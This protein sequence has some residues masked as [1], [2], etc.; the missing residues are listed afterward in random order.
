[1][2]KIL[3]FLVAVATLVACEDIQDNS[4]A[5]Q[6]EINNVLFK[7]LGSAATINGD[8]TIT[9]QAS[10]QDETLTLYLNRV[11]DGTFELGTGNGSFA[12]FEDFSGNTYS[13]LSGGEGVVTISSLD[14]GNSISGTFR[15]QAVLPDL[16][17]LFA[18]RG[19]FFEVPIVPEEIDLPDDPEPDPDPAGTLVARVDTE[20]FNPDTVTAMVLD[21]T[22]II[23]GILDD[24][25][26]E[27]GI[28]LTAVPNTTTLPDTVYFANYILGTVSEMATAGNIRVFQHNVNARTMKGTFSFL[29]E[30]HTISQG[31]FNIMY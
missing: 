5:L 29:T 14:P 3:L 27:L 26:I 7:S 12:A 16:D 11:S 4:P 2:K 20:V 24:A 25:T 22:I 9:I 8:T 1:M 18:Q 15:F 17:T 19:V 10:N 28:P 23:Q 6:A 31:Q 13:T 21:E 30:N